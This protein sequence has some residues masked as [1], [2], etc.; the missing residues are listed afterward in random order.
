MSAERISDIAAE[1][2]LW[3]HVGKLAD[4]RKEAAKARAVER[5]KADGVRAVDAVA[6]EKMIGQIFASRPK[7]SCRIEDSAG[8]LV[9]VKERYPEEIVE[10]VRAPFQKKL[11]D[12]A[13]IDPEGDVWLI[14]EVCPAAVSYLKD[15]TYTVKPSE[16]VAGVVSEL[17]AQRRFTLDGLKE[18][19]DG[20]IDAE[21]VDE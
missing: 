16:D 21:V 11:L 14:G 19:A 13:V 5:M 17:I 4:E 3:A 9:W 6:L 7:Q 18:L 1:A 10:A 12:S 20:V 2:V 8:F 15:P